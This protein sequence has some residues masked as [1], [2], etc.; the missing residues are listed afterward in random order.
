MFGFR[1]KKKMP[2]AE[3]GDGID[4]LAVKIAD[5]TARDK[6]MTTFGASI[7]GQGH[8]YRMNAVLSTDELSRFERKYEVQLPEHYAAFLTRIGNGG[9]G[10]YYG[11]YSLD[12]AVSDDPAHKCRNFLASPFPLT[13]FYNPFDA[14][15][16][17]SDEELFDDKYICGSIVL[18]HQGCG[19]FD[20]LVITGPQAGQVWSDG[21]VS[22]QGIAPLN[23]DFYTWYDHWLTDAIYDL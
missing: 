8:H 6:K 14:N 21:R 2:T 7:Y 15:E 16:D 13:E 11:L 5:L 18:C 23:C 17:A 1:R 9:I 19:Y 22:D 20:R 12:A 4:K 10:P 3:T